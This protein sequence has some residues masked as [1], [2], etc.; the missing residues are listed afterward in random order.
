MTLEINNNT[1]VRNKVA[2]VGLAWVIGVYRTGCQIHYDVTD[3]NNNISFESHTLSLVSLQ[4]PP[5]L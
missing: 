3:K 2:H 1:D 5:L 4:Y